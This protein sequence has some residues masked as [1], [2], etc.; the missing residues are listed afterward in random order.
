MKLINIVMAASMLMLVMGSGMAAY[1]PITMREGA[2]I[3]LNEGYVLG[4][5]NATT[6]QGLMTLSQKGYTSIWDYGVYGDGTTDVTA[7]LQSTLDKRGTVVWPAGTYR[8]NAS[9]GLHV[10]DNTNLIMDPNTVIKNLPYHEQAYHQLL[11]AESHNVKISGGVLDGNKAENTETLGASGFGINIVSCDNI[12]IDCVRSINQWGDGICVMTKDEGAT[13][14]HNININANCYGNRRQGLTFDDA[15]GAVIRGTYTNTSGASPE[16]GIDFEPYSNEVISG[17]IIENVH[18]TNNTGVGIL[19]TLASS[20]P[21][22]TIPFDLKISNHVD[23][24]SYYGIQATSS[25]VTYPGN[26]IIDNPTWKNSKGSGFFAYSWGRYAPKVVL[27]NPTVINC[28]RLDRASPL[29]GAFSVYTGSGVS[30]S[31]PCGNV[32]IFNPTIINTIGYIAYM[33]AL[34]VDYRSG[35]HMYDCSF[36]DPISRNTTQG[37]LYSDCEN[38]LFSDARSLMSAGLPNS[39]YSMVYSWIAREYSNSGHTATRTI[40]L[41]NATTA[42]IC[43]GSTFT[44]RIAVAQYLRLDPTSTEIIYPLGIS[45][46]KY[47]QS[48]TVGSRVTLKKTSTGWNI[49]EQIGTW[50]A[51]A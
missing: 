42:E 33:P 32:H 20:A 40:A 5:A 6:A 43:T 1:G 51:E 21:Y 31:V 38:L 27:K 48:N 36:V 15:I 13:H 4:A 8:I 37:I 11:L 3:T 22:S 26:V 44:F 12:T 25:L 7:E 39:D 29:N 50:T 17:V 34:F 45:A 28:N 24:G 14:N 23:D 16:A 46:G 2:N 10:Y 18:T 47:I 19:I 30:G 35:Q 41:G 49:I 9:M